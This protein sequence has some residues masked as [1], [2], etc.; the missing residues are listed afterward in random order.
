MVII[1]QV[2][3][4]GGYVAYVTELVRLFAHQ[5]EIP[6]VT[7]NI[8]VTQSYLRAMAGG[9]ASK[10]A[11]MARGSA[12][13]SNQP[14]LPNFAEMNIHELVARRLQE[15][16]D[17]GEKWSG[18]MPYMG[19]VE[20]IN[21]GDPGIIVAG[22]SPTYSGKVMILND[23]RSAS[24][25]DFFPAI[26]QKV[27]ALVFGSTSRGLGGPVYSSIDSLGAV[28]MF[29][30][31]TFGVCR[32][33]NGLP[34]ENI[35]VVPDVQRDFT[36]EDLRRGGASFAL[37]ALKAAVLYLQ[38]KTPD[39]IT[40][41]IHKK[42]LAPVIVTETTKELSDKAALIIKVAEKGSLED[43]ILA[44]E[45]LK[46]EF[47]EKSADVPPEE[48]S[49]LQIPIPSVLFEKDLMLSSVKERR[50]VL[51][52]L[53]D[54][55]R[56]PRFQSDADL[57]RLIQVVKST[58]ESTHPEVGVLTPCSLQLWNVAKQKQGGKKN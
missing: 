17:A 19:S 49:R 9:E 45:A 40:A 20:N 1:D 41:Y 15:K 29:F 12:L 27:R 21:E 54:M 7:T 33:A 56:L 30:R 57:A 5:Q 55:T 46:A 39:E 2:S 36:V 6:A 47:A 38:G 43:L 48:F 58:I 22:G 25:G 42:T 3:N 44:Y 4:N 50:G 16:L 35:G 14:D 18:Y 28:Q 23:R 53:Q 13:A 10:A 31:C 26:M 11:A 8:R 34:F 24:G 32:R 52:R 37:D 51:D